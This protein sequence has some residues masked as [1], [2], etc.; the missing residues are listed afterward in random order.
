MPIVTIEWYEGRSAEQKRELAERLTDLLV[1]VGKTQP[2]H[3]WIRFKDS[4]QS[5]WAMGG[6]VQGTGGEPALGPP[7]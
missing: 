5:D 4:K 6:K 7:D 1:E 2:E 3:V